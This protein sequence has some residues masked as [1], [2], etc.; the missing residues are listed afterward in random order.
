[1]SGNAEVRGPLVEMKEKVLVVLIILLSQDVLQSIKC[2]LVECFIPEEQCKHEGG[3]IGLAEVLYIYIYYCLCN[4][5][6]FL[7]N[8]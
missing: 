1:V 2:D 4:T 7:L 3:Y 5:S 6:R 8:E